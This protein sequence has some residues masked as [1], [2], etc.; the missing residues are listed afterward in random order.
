M[1]EDLAVRDLAGVWRLVSFHD[2]DGEGAT[3][4]GPLGPDPAGLLFYAAD[5]FV[6]VHMMR[7]VEHRETGDGPAERPT[8]GYMSYAGT[9]RRFGDQVVHTLTVAPNPEWIG[10]DQIRDLTLDG[11]RLTLY[12][13]ALVGR[14]QRRVL[15]W[16]RVVST[17]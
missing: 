15:E 4:E 1:T 14:P 17:G 10:T 2:I 16:H 5:G 7:T 3:R 11:D 9:W 8:P 6:S 12:G 13:D